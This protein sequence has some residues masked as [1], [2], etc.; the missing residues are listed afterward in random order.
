M[1]TELEAVERWLSRRITKPC[2]NND[3]DDTCD[4]LWNG[5]LFLGCPDKCKTCSMDS[6]KKVTCSECDAEY[7]SAQG[8]ICDCELHLCSVMTT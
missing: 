8:K 7:D 1:L 5:D 4:A 2:D 6:D 3:D